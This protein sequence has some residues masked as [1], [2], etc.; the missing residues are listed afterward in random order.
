MVTPFLAR[1]R[2]LFVSKEDA[3]QSQMARAYAQQYAGDKIEAESAGTS[4][5]GEINPLMEEVMSEQGIDM[6]FR[7]PRSTEVAAAEGTPD[8]IVS[9]G[10]KDVYLP[11]PDAKNDVWDLPGPTGESVSSMR[12]MRDN[13]RQRVERL[14]GTEMSV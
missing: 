9:F 12:E 10:Q 4:P 7:K 6:A 3:C 14:I 1:K 2:I 5:A 8:L 11:F 13:I